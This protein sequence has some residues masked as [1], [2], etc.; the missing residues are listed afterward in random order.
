MQ[1]P[2]LQHI[3]VFPEGAE[4]EEIQVLLKEALNYVVFIPWSAGVMS[5]WEHDLYEENLSPKKY[6]ERWWGYVRKFQ[7]VAPPLRAIV[8]H[9]RAATA[10]RAAAAT[11]AAACAATAVG[12]ARTS[13]ITTGPRPVHDETVG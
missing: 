9:P 4:T 11:C 3:G 5:H 8:K 12:S 7:G 13:T 10:S 2:F 1:K 6:N